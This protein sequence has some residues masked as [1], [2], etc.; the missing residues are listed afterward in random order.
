MKFYKQIF[1]SISLQAVALLLFVN[2]VSAQDDSH[3]PELPHPMNAT[4]GILD[5]VGSF[6]ARANMFRQ[7]NR[8]G[9]SE[10]D[11]SG[12]FSYGLSDVGGLHLRSLGIRTTPLT[13][14]IGMLSL[15][16]DESKL[17]G[18]SFIG[19][20]GIPTGKKNGDEHHG[21]S[22]LAG[23][24][25]R[26]TVSDFINND[27]ILHYDLT[28]KHYIAESGTVVRLSPNIFGLLDTKITIGNTVQPEV[29]F[30]P[31][32][33]V[34]IFSGGFVGVGYNTPITTYSTFN[35]QLF[36]QFEVGSH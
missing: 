3:R 8:D 31:S 2:G 16:Q 20:L 6:N 25:G 32:V 29:L 30:M 14:L 5:P 22:Y 33:K 12:H 1:F 36:I 15:W 9:N 17:Q 10:I 4:M 11:I 21:L 18:I 27:I 34:R 26:V 13:E 35:N 7:Q 28:A 23:L 19:I 24:S